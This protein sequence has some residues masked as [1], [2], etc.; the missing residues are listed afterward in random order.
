MTQL[1][2]S[3]R[4]ILGSA[5][6]TALPG[7]PV[8]PAAW[9][10]SHGP[11]ARGAHHGALRVGRRS[12]PATLPLAPARCSD[13]RRR[14]PSRHD[15]AD[16]RQPRPRMRQGD[17]FMMRRQAAAH[18]PSPA[19]AGAATRS[20]TTPTPPDDAGQLPQATAEAD[21]EAGFRAV[22]TA[23]YGAYAGA[24]ARPSSAT[25]GLAIPLRS[26]R[27]SPRD[28]GIFGADLWPATG[29]RWRPTSSLP[30]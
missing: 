8:P 24:R 29:M 6:A 23:L 30:W 10:R 26:I 13:L 19:G 3:R 25:P 11:R 18:L 2:P 1:R 15:R 7:S 28:I 20:V 17:F 5:F 14:P 22:D 12:Y 9:R 16:P 21:I 27:G 4:L